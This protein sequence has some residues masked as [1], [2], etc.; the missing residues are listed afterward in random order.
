VGFNSDNL[1]TRYIHSIRKADKHW[2]K[3]KQE[4]ISQIKQQNGIGKKDNLA[5]LNA[6]FSMV[7][8]RPYAKTHEKN[9]VKDFVSPV[10]FLFGLNENDVAN[11]TGDCDTRTLA[12]FFLLKDDDDMDVAI[13]NFNS[14]DPKR[15]PHHSMIGIAS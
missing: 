12:L 13:F 5:Y 14:P 4:L 9:L 6:L 7:Q 8:S 3:E 10:H 11:F 1:S 2:S 15:F